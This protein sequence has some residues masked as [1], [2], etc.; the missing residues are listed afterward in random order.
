MKSYQNCIPEVVRYCATPVLVV[1]VCAALAG[2]PRAN[3]NDEIVIT[4]TDESAGRGAGATTHEDILKAARSEGELTWYTSMPQEQADALADM[5]QEE[6]PFIRVR[7]VRE[8]TFDIAR[9][10]QD[11]VATG[12]TAADVIHVLDP[13][14]FISLRKSGQLY[15][16]EPRE[17]KAIPPAYKDPGYWTTAR[18]V[19]VCIAVKTGAIPRDQL[20]TT[21]KE[22]LDPVWHR[23]MA[24]KDAQT[25]GSA[26]AQYYF[27]RDRYG[28]SY[29]EQ[30][31]DQ[32]P[33]IYK[34]EDHG[35]D[36]LI[37]GD[38]K[39]AAGV[40]GYK[41]YQYSQ[42]QGEPV[43]AIWPTDGVP[44][45]LGPVAILRTCPH[46]NTAK[47]FVEYILS[48]EGQAAI[49]RLLGSYSM[50]PDVGAPE[51]RVELSELNLFAARDGWQDYLEK[52]NAL[53]REYGALFSPGS[54]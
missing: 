46:P 33:M 20:P 12:H 34:S 4:I 53:H 31:A 16:Y 38:V 7:I 43:E 52:Q 32:M 27:L 1:V 11:E 28:V 45:C 49:T 15:R 54:E 44:V 47:L 24:L 8:G 36:A 2:C 35:L 25:G 41:V 51:G 19:T 14:I 3:R 17:S 39:I 37:R 50:R 48:R 29:W 10:V 40:L 13:G 9:R 6:Y 22:L 23:Q 5:F 26:Y 18:L 42:L 30:F 21:W